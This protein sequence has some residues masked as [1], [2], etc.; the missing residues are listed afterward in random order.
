MKP[1]EIKLVAACIFHD[2]YDDDELPFLV[3]VG[4]LL[5][6]VKSGVDPWLLALLCFLFFFDLVQVLQVTEPV[7]KPTSGAVCGDKIKKDG[8]NKVSVN[9]NVLK[10]L[11]RFSFQRLA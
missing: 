5:N 4:T 6:H 11:E 1:R 10:A 3:D 7:V 2:Q 8:N 9:F